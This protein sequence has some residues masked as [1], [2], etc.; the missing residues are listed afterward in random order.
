[1]RKRIS[2]IAFLR[3]NSTNLCGTPLTTSFNGSTNN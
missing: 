2:N 1:M 3:N